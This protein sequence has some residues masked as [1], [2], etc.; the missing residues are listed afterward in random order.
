[1]YPGL[2]S[3]LEREIKQLYLERVL[4]NDSDKLAKF[5]IRIEDPPRRKD[6]VFIGGAVLA[7][8][9]KNRD[10][11]WLTRQEYQEQGLSCL[12][13]LGPRAS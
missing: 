11:F 6:M 4:R 2:P 9:C 1:M 12:R 10:N 8:V 5:K 7:E 13:K 3:R